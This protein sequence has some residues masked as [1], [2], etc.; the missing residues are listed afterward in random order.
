MMPGSVILPNGRMITPA[1]TVMK[2]FGVYP[3][4]MEATP[5]GKFLVITSIGEQP[6]LKL[7]SVRIKDDAGA[8]QFQKVSE[9]VK[10]RPESLS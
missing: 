5:D 9:Q 10:S 2:N 7:I 6:D 8:V 3:L 4:N 1:G